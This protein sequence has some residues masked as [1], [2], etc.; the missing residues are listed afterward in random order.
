M[1]FEEIDYIVSM[2]EQE[3]CVLLLGPEI[4]LTNGGQVIHKQLI[5]IP[6]IKENENILYYENEELFYFKDD[7]EQMPTYNKIIE[8]YKQQSPNELHKIISQIPFHLIFSTSPDLLLKKT[9]DEQGMPNNF[10]FFSKANKLG[11]LEKPTRINPLIFNIFG[12]ISDD[13]SMI[14]THNDLFDY[15]FAILS[16]NV[17]PTDLMSELQSA[18]FFIFIGFKFDKWY[19]NLIFKLLKISESKGKREAFIK[20]FKGDSLVLYSNLFKIKFIEN[21]SE[22]FLN[23]LLE[24]CKAKNLIRIGKE[25]SEPEIIKSV[26][27]DIANDN[28]EEALQKLETYLEDKSEDLCDQVVLQAGRFRKLQKNINANTISHENAEID[29]AKIKN[30]LL[31]IANEAKTL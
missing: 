9:F 28:I 14:F 27:K 3:K 12:S 11:K 24:K 20:D 16:A 18:R 15:L 26:K 23:V 22:E 25:V 4:A 21:N 5:N 10:S 13:E 6:K 7:T 29:H 19:L 17:L 30:A 1:N 2:I 31:D 8:F